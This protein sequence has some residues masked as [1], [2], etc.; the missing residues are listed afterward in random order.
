[1]VCSTRMAVSSEGTVEMVAGE[2]LGAQCPVIGTEALD[3]GPERSRVVHLAQV[4]EL[5]AHDVVDEMRRRLH[6]PPGE[7]YLATRV[8]APPARAR[9]GDGE[10]RRRDAARA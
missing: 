3:L 9:R 7:A 1:M 10:P 8:A 5:V 6:Q 4:R 2:E